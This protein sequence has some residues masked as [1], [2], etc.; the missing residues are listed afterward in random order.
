MLL[1][2]AKARHHHQVPQSALQLPFLP[3]LLPLFLLS[4]PLGGRLAIDLVLLP[5]VPQPTRQHRLRLQH[6][7][8]VHILA[9]EIDSGS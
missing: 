9:S 4:L 2:R 3:P 1:P 6:R 7:Q 5:H 8:P